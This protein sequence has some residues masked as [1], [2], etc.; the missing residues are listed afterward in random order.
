VAIPATV[1]FLIIQR[2]LVGGL[3]SGAVKS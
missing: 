1:L 2:R 3:T